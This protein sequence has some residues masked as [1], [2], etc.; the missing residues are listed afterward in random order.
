MKKALFAGSFDPFTTGHDSIVRRALTI[1]DG[2]VI[3]VAVNGAKHSMYT[4]EERVEA[5]RRLYADDDRIEVVTCSG[6]TVE[7]ARR[8]ET[9]L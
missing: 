2:V 8:T 3:G 1:F 6:L 5:I 7:A 9:S 4:V